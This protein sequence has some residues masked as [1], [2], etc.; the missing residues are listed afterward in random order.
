MKQLRYKGFFTF[1]FFAALLFSACSNLF[2]N[3]L[4]DDLTSKTGDDSLTGGIGSNS[5]IVN[6][7]IN[8]GLVVIKNSAQGVNQITYSA[9]QTLYFVGTVPEDYSD[10]EVTYTNGSETNLSGSD[11]PVEFRCFANDSNASIKWTI[12][13]TWKYIPIEETKTST[14]SEGMEIVYKGISGQY[15]E[16]L[17]KKQTLPFSVVSGKSGVSIIQA[18]LPYGVSLV[19]CQVTADDTNYSTEYKIILTKNY[20]LTTG[21]SS[22]SETDSGNHSLLKSLDVTVNSDTA[23]SSD[24]SLSP[25]FS[26]STTVYNLTVDE[27]ADSISIDAIAQAVGAEISDATIV[28]KYGEVPGSDGMNVS[29]VGGTSR[30]SFSVT[31]ESGI[32]RTYYIYVEKPADG[33]TTLSSLLYSPAASF[34]NGVEGFTFASSYA[35]EKESSAAKYS[36]TLSADDRIDVTSLDFTACPYS[37]RTSVS[38]GISSGETELPSSWSSSFTKDA[39][40]SQNVEFSDSDL[41]GVESA[42]KILWIKT[43]SDKYYHYDSSSKAYSSE[44]T[45]DTTYHKVKITKAGK[46]SKKLT[47]LLVV[48]TYEDGSTKT[49]LSQTTSSKVAYE[50][51]GVTVPSSAGITTFADRLDIYFRPLNKD[52]SVYYTAL[53]TAHSNDAENTNFLGYAS[54]STSLTKES[55]TSSDLGDSVSG[56]YHIQI[57]MIEVGTASKIDLPN[58]TTSVTICGETY[59]FVK[60]DLSTVSYSVSA[61]SSGGGV[62]KTWEDYIYL[63]NSVTSI[64]M[65]FTTTQQNE[66]IEVLSCE[67]TA[68]VD[69]GSVSEVKNA[70]WSLFH[71][72]TISGNNIVKWQLCVGNA[73]ESVE[74]YTY[75]SSGNTLAELIPAGTTTLKVRVS[76]GGSE[77]SSSKDYT[78]YIIRAAD[79]ESRLYRLTFGGATP[80]AFKS[81][82]N[83]GMSGTEFYYS[84]AKTYAVDAGSFTVSAKAVSENSTITLTKYHT[85]EVNVSASSSGYN[86]ASWV[87]GTWSDGDESIEMTGSVSQPYTLSSEDAGTL[88]YKFNVKS[89]DNNSSGVQSE[90]NY[91]LFVY[92]QADK[93]AQLDSLKIIQKGTNEDVAETERDDRTILGNSYDAET[94]DYPDL[95]ASLNYIGDIVISAEKYSKATVTASSLTMDGIDVI[96]NGGASQSGYNF[97][98]PYDSYIENKGKT[99]TVSYTVQAQDTS[100]DPVTYTAQ[101]EIPEYKEVTETKTYSVT[102]EYS[103]EVPSGYSSALGYRFG[104]VITDESSPLKGYFGGLDIVGSSSL[105]TSN[106]VWY[107]SSFAASG[108]QFIVSVDGTNYGVALNSEGEAEK[109]YTF[110]YDSRTVTECSDEDKPNISLKVSP[111]FVYEGS[112]PYLALTFNMT[113]NSASSV[114]LG[115]AIDTLVGTV[116]QAA[117]SDNDSV[118]VVATNNGFTMNG[119]EYTFAVCLKNAYGVDDVDNI[120]YGPYD[121]GKFINNVF[122]SSATSGLSSGEDSAATFSWNLGNDR[123]CKKTI[124][125][126]MKALQ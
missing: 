18:D 114:M 55:G 104:S 46:D 109:F 50:T 65:N 89:K 115:V 40:L 43:V 7:E 70:G 61:G 107:E 120:W 108:L 116:D 66:S 20:T 97:T 119:S 8:T 27:E 13:Q 16:K 48:A 106:P 10:Y 87:Q 22:D 54:S 98:I 83:S 103:Y 84:A 121:G 59:A 4:N 35:G 78:F 57:G 113:N 100:V 28:T 60:P 73:A 62:D 81:D 33:D 9:S 67:Q 77:G 24:A 39:L 45:S 90:R 23:G 71:Y 58:G 101:I 122:D 26:P 76:N 19:T 112:E 124:R 86:S 110:D 52:Q 56:Y 32:S 37:K 93:T 36:M 3:V 31:D 42:T 80:S 51:E 69:G 91:Y 53:N 72:D 79:L 126:T 117:D 118:K 34:D 44:K 5:S 99:Y 25:A 29:L 12:T 85:D 21:D 95:S 96:A 75:K 1:V 64:N 47:A 63:D 15:A 6:S 94:Y 111:S 2:E 123:S 105:N 14:D 38:Y 49:V 30:I 11:N 74:N 92:V 88:L 68:G 41:N 17:D 102:S 82:W 125:F